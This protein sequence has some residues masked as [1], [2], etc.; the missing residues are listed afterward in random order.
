MTLSRTIARPLLAS[1]FVVGGISALR[2]VDALAPKVTPVTDRIVPLAQKAAPSANLPTDAGSWIKINAAVQIGAGLALA[3]GRAPRLAATLLAVSLVPTTV[4]GHPFWSE[5]E[6]VARRTQFMAFVK[7]TSMLGGLL[8][9]AGD[10]EG[11]PG[12]A[13]RAQR[14]AQDVRREARTLTK[15]ARREAKHLASAARREAKLAKAQLT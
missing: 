12:L 7:N 8:I 4:A 15:E 13:W 1:T 6:P 5:S 11:Q 3:T 10:T 14:G 9:A 2:N